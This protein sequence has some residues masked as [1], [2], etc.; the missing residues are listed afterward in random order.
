M[1]KTQFKNTS[2]VLVHNIIFGNITIDEFMSVLHPFIKFESKY[3]HGASIKTLE[4]NGRRIYTF[5]YGQIHFR[6][7]KRTAKIIKFNPF[8]KRYYLMKGILIIKNKPPQYL[9]H[10][11]GKVYSGEEEKIT[12]QRIIFVSTGHRQVKQFEMY[13]LLMMLDKLNPSIIPNVERKLLDI[14]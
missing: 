12:S 6:I 14:L 11:H 8:Y 4:N 10:L 2:K 9:K 7:K 1:R 5:D 3:I 13:T